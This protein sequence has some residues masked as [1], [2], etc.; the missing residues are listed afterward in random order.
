MLDLN[1]LL[2]GREAMKRRVPPLFGYIRTIVLMTAIV[3]GFLSE[4]WLRWFIDAVLIGGL[5]LAF[6]F[7][8]SIRDQD[9]SPPSIIGPEP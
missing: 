1:P 5:L 8:S 3:G 4:P 7:R 9:S 6:L 2:M